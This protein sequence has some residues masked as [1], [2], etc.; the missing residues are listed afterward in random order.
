[1]RI[2]HVVGG[3]DRGGAETWLVQVLRNIDR[4]KY[5]MDFLVHTTKPCAYD[6]EVKSLGSQ[7]IPCL[8]PSHP[9]AYARHFRE[10]L[11]TYGPY[12]CVHSHVHLFS[13]YVI[14]V[15]AACGI[16]IRI[17]HSHIDTRSTQASDRLL[18]KAYNIAM[19]LFLRRCASGGLAV[20]IEAADDLFGPDW[21][22]SNRLTLQHLGINLDRFDVEVDPFAMRQ[23]LGIP[24][25]AVVIGHVGRFVDQ[26]NHAFLL[27]I[28][29]KLVQKEPRCFIFLVGEGPLRP[30][31]EE[32]IQ[33]A[34]LAGHFLS[35]GARSDVPLLMKGAMDLFLFPSVYEGLPL[36]LLEAQA[37]GLKCVISDAVSPE[38]DVIERLI[39]RESLSKSPEDW[40]DR[41][42]MQASNNR[43]MVFAEIKP[44][45]AGRSIQ[46]SAKDLA[47]FYEEMRLRIPIRTHSAKRSARVATSS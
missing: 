24:A 23:R 17:I 6:E 25:E 3:L 9:V 7:I 14:L 28:S 39:Q 13:G 47:A 35:L 40:A 43:R 33:S 15:A 19:R 34:G 27:E 32:E 11:N 1:M 4:S 22:T 20:S 45:L 31:I 12:D 41:I 5:Q 26:K 36:T 37:A 30:K 46:T 2:L 18:R 21:R 44:L 8:S 16:P 29:K 10:I 42:L 38:A